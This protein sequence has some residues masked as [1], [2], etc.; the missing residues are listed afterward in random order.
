MNI[1]IKAT[2]IIA[3]QRL[4]SKDVLLTLQGEKERK[5]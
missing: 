5:K 4:L 2:N 1:E 3:A